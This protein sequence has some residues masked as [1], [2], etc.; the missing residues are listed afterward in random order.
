M[1]VFGDVTRIIWNVVNL[2]IGSPGEMS[3]NCMRYGRTGG[4]FYD[5]TI[6]LSKDCSEAKVKI[7]SHSKQ[8]FSPWDGTTDGVLE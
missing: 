4:G 6:E 7:I 5:I 1:G 3:F 2:Y 8:D